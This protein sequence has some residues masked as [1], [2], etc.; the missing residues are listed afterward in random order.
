MMRMMMRMMM[1][2]LTF[3]RDKV[4]FYHIDLLQIAQDTPLEGFFQSG[5]LEKSMN[6]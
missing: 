5:K 6:K 3:F 4:S 1:I 2:I